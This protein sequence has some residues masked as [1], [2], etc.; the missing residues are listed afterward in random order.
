[1]ELWIRRR[2]T[3]P[4]K[5]LSEIKPF[6]WGEK[7]QRISLEIDRIIYIV[8]QMT[9]LYSSFIV[10]YSNKSMW[11]MRRVDGTSLDPAWRIFKEQGKPMPSFTGYTAQGS[12]GLMG[13]QTWRHLMKT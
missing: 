11:A 13:Y 10:A 3:K 12:A 8:R 9:L 2:E 6:H 7:T 4:R 1:M 5:R